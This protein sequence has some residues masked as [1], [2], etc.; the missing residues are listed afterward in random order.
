MWTWISWI[1]SRI[2]QKVS[3]RNLKQPKRVSNFNIVDYDSGFIVTNLQ[4]NINAYLE[5][6]SLTW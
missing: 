5:G 4:K 6:T 3:D 2:E 1:L